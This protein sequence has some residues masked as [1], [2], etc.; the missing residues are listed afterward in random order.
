MRW[1]VPRGLFLG[2]LV[3]AAAWGCAPT[4]VPTHYYIL[5]AIP[6]GGA[7]PASAG[8]L[9][10]GVGPFT[11][12][13]YLDR[14]QIVTRTGRD[15][16]DLADFDQWGEPLRSAVLRVLA[17]DLAARI[18][19]PRIVPFPWR[20]TR[21]VQYQVVVE[22]LR[23][24]GRLGGDAAL[25]ARWRVLDSAGREL[26][27]RMS[28]VTE[29]TSGPGYGALVAALSRA[30][31]TLSGEIATAIAAMPRSGGPPGTGRAALSSR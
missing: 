30:L 14:P 23:F 15:E 25:D 22:I 13:S 9:T 4:P 29:A 16:I 11:V 8:D 3:A 31:G 24:E 27:L 5:T 12:P 6:P 18:P 19:T 10:S 20:G 7:A 26:A 21:T 28:T 1:S 2:A 17:E